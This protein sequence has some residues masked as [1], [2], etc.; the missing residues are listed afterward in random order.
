MIITIQEYIVMTSFACVI[1]IVDFC[2]TIIFPIFPDFGTFVRPSERPQQPIEC[3]SQT[4]SHPS[5]L[6]LD[7]SWTKSNALPL[8]FS[9][10]DLLALVLRLCYCIFPKLLAHPQRLTTASSMSFGN[11]AKTYR[12]VRSQSIAKLPLIPWA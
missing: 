9:F 12:N 3:R 7:C 8:R 1:V 2:T 6:V 11:I 5:I 4:I 10:L